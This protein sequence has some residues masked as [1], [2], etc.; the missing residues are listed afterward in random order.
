VALTGIVCAHTLDIISLETIAWND[1]I[2]IKTQHNRAIYAEK[3]R[4]FYYKIWDRN[5]HRASL[6]INA[7]ET[8]FFK[9]I[10][11][12]RGVIYD[13]QNRC[14]GYV[15]IGGVLSLSNTDKSCLK[16]T[17]SYY[18]LPTRQQTNANYIRFYHRLV[19][20]TTKYR[21]AF[22]DLSPTN[23]IEIDAQFYLIDLESVE[24]LSTL[25]K[26][27]ENHPQYS[28]HIPEYAQDVKR[29]LNR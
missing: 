29:L 25:T 8:G 16:M 18:I 20:N 21:Y 28:F 9:K 1:L 4:S 27:F 24:P 17:P 5:Y 7:L 22:I 23:L 14:R 26:N 19:K 13:K 3:D 11:P 10:A 6:F 12:L 2:S 15:T